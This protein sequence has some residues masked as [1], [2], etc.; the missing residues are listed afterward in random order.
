MVT[1]NR[2]GS[3]PSVGDAT[4]TSL[5]FPLLHRIFQGFSLHLDCSRL[6][7]SMIGDGLV[8][9]ASCEPLSGF[10]PRNFACFCERPFPITVIGWSRSGRRPPT[11]SACIPRSVEILCD[12][13]LCRRGALS[14]VTCEGGSKLLRIDKSAFSECQSLA[15]I[16]L[17]SSVELPSIRIGL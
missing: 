8:L 5:L 2:L 3:R 10:S 12:G 11:V 17:T 16:C 7:S 15:S 6:A 9:C 14:G 4:H 1:M 13:S